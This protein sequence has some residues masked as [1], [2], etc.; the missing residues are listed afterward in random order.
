MATYQEQIDRARLK[1]D[2]KANAGL[3][4]G[5]GEL[6]EYTT[7]LT[8][9]LRLAIEAEPRYSNDAR[10]VPLVDLC[11]AT[12]AVQEHAAALRDIK[13]ISAYLAVCAHNA[14]VFLIEDEESKRIRAAETIMAICNQAA[15]LTERG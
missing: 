11:A 2:A 9:R 13:H 7:G 8:A 14:E 3:E 1:R 5:C 12:Q 10:V 4:R 6:A 15:I